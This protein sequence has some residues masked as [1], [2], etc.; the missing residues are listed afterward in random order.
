MRSERASRSPKADVFLKCVQGKPHGGL[1]EGRARGGTGQALSQLGGGE[2]AL[3]PLRK[4]NPFL[5]HHDGVS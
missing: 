1:V 3:T 5:C 2:L 4:A